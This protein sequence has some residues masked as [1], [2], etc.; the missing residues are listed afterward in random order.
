MSSRARARP[1]TRSRARRSESSS[2]ATRVAAS[3][4][5]VDQLAGASV[6]EDVFRAEV[7][8]RDD[9]S[10]AGHR[11]GVRDAETLVARRQA[12]DPG[13]SV[14]RRP[15]PRRRAGRGRELPVRESGGASWVTIRAAPPR[16][17]RG[18]PRA[19][20]ASAS[21]APRLRPSQVPTKRTVG[22]VGPSCGDRVEALGVHAVRDHAPDPRSPAPGLPARRPRCVSAA[23]LAS[24]S[25]NPRSH[26]PRLLLDALDG[27]RLLEA[28]AVQGAHVHRHA[29]APHPVVVTVGVQNVVAREVHPAQR[30]GEPKGAQ[31]AGEPD[32]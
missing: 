20:N 26:H 14:L 10:P 5:Q 22:R 4:R 6:V 32:T 3:V 16:A 13:P 29:A 31:R 24:T 9:R 25:V 11:L 21:A 28:R 23:R 18:A 7:R 19:T 8:R 17:P 12:E 27:Q 30:G 1:A 2:R 15:A